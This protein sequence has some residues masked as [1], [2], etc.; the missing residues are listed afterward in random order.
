MNF[1]ISF[2]YKSK[3]PTTNGAISPS[4]FYMLPLLAAVRPYHSSIDKN[5]GRLGREHSCKRGITV[6]LLLRLR[7]GAVSSSSRDGRKT[8]VPPSREGGSRMLRGLMLRMEKTFW[9]YD[10]CCS[11]RSPEN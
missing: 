7:V 11:V 8:P 10:G 3:L 9:V 4:H 6:G 1:F 5:I 2:R